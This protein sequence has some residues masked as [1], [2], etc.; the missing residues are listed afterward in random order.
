MDINFF[1][2]FDTLTNFPFTTS[3]TKS[4]KHGIY[5]LPHEL[6]NFFRLRILGN[7]ERS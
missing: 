1:R 4:D 7:Y 6:L 3:E 2:L 5:E